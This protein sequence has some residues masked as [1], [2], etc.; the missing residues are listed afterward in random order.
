MRS[1]LGIVCDAYVAAGFSR[2]REVDVDVMGKGKS[3]FHMHT[4]C[5]KVNLDYGTRQIDAG[6]PPPAF[7]K[8][9]GSNL[10]YRC[11]WRI[12]RGS[13]WFVFTGVRESPT[14]AQWVL[15]CV[16]GH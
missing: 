3:K 13:F 15:D 12:I 14:L 16:R 6:K 1:M 2:I 10:L 4:P 7:L 11:P 5:S 9:S 8:L